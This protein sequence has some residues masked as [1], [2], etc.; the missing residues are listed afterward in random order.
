VHIGAKSDGP[1]ERLGVLFNQVPV[2]A[3]LPLYAMPTA[4]AMQAA[5]RLGVF[6]ELAGGAATAGELAQKLGLR[7]EGTKLL[8]DTLCVTE[9]LRV[10][11]DQRYELARRSHKWL[12]PSSDSYIGGF[13]ADS[14]FWWEWWEGLEDLIKDGRSVEMHDR[15]VDDPYW[16]S[17]ITGQYQVARLTSDTVAKAVGLGEDATSL[18]DVAGGH[19]EFSMALCRRHR[20]LRATIVDLPGSARVGREIV[21]EAG[22][23]DRVDFVEGDMFEAE[24]GGP[25]DGVLCFNIIHHLDPDGARRLFERVAAALRPGAPLCVL[26]LFDR[27]SGKRPDISSMLGLFFHLTSGADTYT[28]DEVSDW[29]TVSGYE[30]PKRKTFLQL[31]GLAL[32]RAERSA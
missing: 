28:A 32:L 7:D 26:D 14:H 29:L 4:R 12:D 9:V 15:P 23:T 21:G 30:T 24:L 2:P 16:P 22:M 17:Y 27:P 20:D 8:L 6:R 10:R 31:P 25:H 1:V 19:G 5:Q 13:V 18:L 11:S 3:G